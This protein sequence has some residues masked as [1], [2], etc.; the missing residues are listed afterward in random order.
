ML[1]NF[2]SLTTSGVFLYHKLINGV[3][4]NWQHGCGKLA[5][6]KLLECRIGRREN[7]GQMAVQ[8]SRVWK[9]TA[10]QCENRSEMGGDLE[11]HNQGHHRISLEKHTKKKKKINFKAIFS[12]FPWT[13]MENSEQPRLIKMQESNNIEGRWAMLYQ[14]IY[15]EILQTVM[16]EPRW[17]SWTVSHSP[18][19]T[20]DV[21]TEGK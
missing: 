15:C 20:N 11:K 3:S 19:K 5:L 7:R 9:T 13:K 14:F 16:L 4:R 6:A 2:S 18:R 1:S 8:C 12:W 10:S 17:R 21:P